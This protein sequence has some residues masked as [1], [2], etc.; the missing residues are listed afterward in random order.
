MVYVLYHFP[1]QDGFGSAYSAWKK[2]KDQAKYIPVNY[3]KD[4]P[5]MPDA[6]EVYIIDFAFSKEKLL[7][8]KAKVPVVV[9]LDHHITAKEQLQD[10][11]FATFDMNKSGSG[12][13]WDYF[14]PQTPRPELINHIEDRDL[15]KFSLPDTEEIC[16]AL[17][18]HPWDFQVWDS[19]N[20]DTLRQEGKTLKRYLKILSSDVTRNCFLAEID[21][22][23][24]PV[25]NCPILVSDIGEEM[26]QKF[27]KTKQY[28]FVGLYYDT[29][30]GKRKWSLRS[31]SDSV[32]VA[33]VAEKFKGGGHRNSS[34]LIEEKPFD[35]VKGFKKLPKVSS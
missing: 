4:L 24:F 15:W 22:H 10:L 29:K 5:D 31:C 3:G 12:L 17:T 11:D 35:I 26:L 25:V 18:S 13:S 33:K 27:V 19:L 2:F 34:G 30:D 28:P 32:D 6:S 16:L 14:H 8:L 1:C 23:T 9:V 21:G 20:L 7:E